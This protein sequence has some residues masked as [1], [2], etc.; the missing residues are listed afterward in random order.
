MHNKAANLLCYDGH[1]ES[2][3]QKEFQNFNEIGTDNKA[4]PVK[5]AYDSG[6]GNYVSVY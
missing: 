1:V 6:T 5:W 3:R 4:Y 2:A